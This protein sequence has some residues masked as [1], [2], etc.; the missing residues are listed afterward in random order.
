[1]SNRG[2]RLACFL[3]R[4]MPGLAAVVPP[5]SL[6]AWPAQAVPLC[7]LTDLGTL[8]GDNSVA[9]A[10]NDSGQIVDSA[11]TAVI[12]SHAF[13]FESG[14]RF[15]LNDLIDPRDPPFGRVLLLEARD[16]NADG[17]L[18]ASGSLE[19]FAHHA[20]L[21]P[22]RSN[23]CPRQEHSRCWRWALPRASGAP[24]AAGLVYQKRQCILLKPQETLSLA[25]SGRLSGSP[26]GPC[27]RERAADNRCC[28]RPQ[29][30]RTRTNGHLVDEAAEVP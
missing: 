25:R 22:F 28:R 24:P 10:I 15:D 26:T 11:Q 7:R 9:H 6:L 14:T 12:L 29:S 3:R 5:A 4:A 1:M 19:S 21:H 27:A 30:S 13:L 17:A 16:L 18:V 23:R 20:F 8:G 2:L